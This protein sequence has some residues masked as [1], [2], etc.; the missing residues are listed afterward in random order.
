M[1][2]PNEVASMH[3]RRMTR[4]LGAAA[5]GLLGAAFLPAATAFAD[6]G[7]DY[8]NYDLVPNSQD[9]VTDG[10]IR[11]FLVEVP[12]GAAGSVQG[13]Q[14]LVVDSP[15]GTPVGTIEVDVTNSTDIFDNTNQEILVT[16]DLTGTP[17]S[18]AG[19]VP[20][21]GS[22]FDTEAYTS[23][24]QAI[25]TDIPGAGANGTDLVSYSWDSAYGDSTIP[26]SYDAI[27]T[28]V[29]VG[30]A[31]AGAGFTGDTFVL[32]GPETIEGVNGIAPADY[33][34]LGTQT[35][36]VD[37]SA[38]EQIG[39]FTAEVAN[40][41]DILGNTT[42]DMLVTSSTGDAPAV[43]S[44]YDYFFTGT[45]ASDSTYNVYADIPTSGGADTVTDNVVSPYGSS[46]LLFDFDAAKGLAGVLDGTSPLATGMSTKAFDITPDTSMSPN[47]DATITA[48]DGIQPEDI[49]V[50][51]TQEFNWDPG[52]AQ[53][54]VF[55]AD[56]AQSTIIFGN[57]T[58]EQLVVTQ[59]VSGDA[60]QVGSVF[61]VYNYGDGFEQVYS[62]I[63]TS[64]GNEITDTTVTPF[65]DFSVPD[66]YDAS[67]VLANDS[68]EKFVE[69]GSAA[70]SLD[71]SAAVDS[72]SFAELFPQL[73]AALN[74]LTGLF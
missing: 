6:E 22:V 21:V 25:Y 15:S 23:G 67:A 30:V 29:P 53:A 5:G 45:A 74:L 47:A 71:P 64:N 7:Y 14:E 12:P 48:V 62:D 36:D 50:Q 57:T 11:N 54:G 43:G 4:T 65:G 70:A 16:A 41:S 42:Q 38:G 18:A 63:V 32:D 56:V 10:G 58:Q 34:L 44:V 31:G 51:G 68:A 69:A 61:E 39:T 33:D 13:T 49:D 46:A 9:V 35:F 3:R 59:D 72:G 55:D 40:S 66:D 37:N 2:T 26:T 52:T 24:I 28:V 27:T 20:P 1:S 8:G 19:D 60:P 17:G 73:D